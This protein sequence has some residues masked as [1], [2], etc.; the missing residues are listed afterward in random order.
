MKLAPNC[1]YLLIFW[2]A[3]YSSVAQENRKLDSLLEVYKKLPDDTAKV[4]VLQKIFAEQMSN[5]KISDAQNFARIQLKL[6]KKINYDEGTGKA[7]SNLAIGYNS[8]YV[9]DSARYYYAK[10]YKL[11]EKIGDKGQLLYTKNSWAKVEHLEGNYDKALAMYDETSKMAVEINDGVE[12]FWA[13]R[14]KASVYMDKGSYKLALQEFL[15]SLKVLDTLEGNYKKEKGNILV[16]MGR[17]ED[18]RENHEAS[19]K[20]LDEAMDVFIREENSIWQCITHTEMGLTYFHMGEYEKS[21]DKFNNALDISIRLERKNFE[22]ICYAN[23]GMVLA[24]NGNPDKALEYLYRSLKMTK[25]TNSNLSTTYNDIGNAFIVK[26]NFSKAIENYTYAIQL[27]E[28]V[29]GIGELKNSHQLRSMAFEQS[30]QYKEALQ[31]QKQYLVLNDSIFNT[32]KSQQ[33]EELRTIY[34]TEKKEQQI[35]LQEKE[36]TVLEQK[37]SISSLQRI[38]M[39]IGLLLSLIGF[40]AIR[41]KLKRNKLEKEKLDVELDF[42]K[43]ELTT[44]ALH[45]AKK[46]EVLEGLKQKAEELKTSDNGQN[47]YQQLIRTINFDL[48]NDNNWQNFSKYFQ[49]VHTNFN[50][51]VK[52]KFPKVTSNELRLMSLL[53]MNLSSKEIANILNISQEGIKKARYRLR[54]KLEITS[55]NSL[56]DLVLSL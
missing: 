11:W 45:L 36:I 30:G 38:V 48:Q 12:L 51:N 53:K 22:A 2:C 43:K 9:F 15:I 20:Y 25:N 7:L 46:N 47:G 40:Y 13:K 42:K 19:M 23:I 3:I 31:D 55:E 16:G 21:L 24:K 26:K 41:Q 6:S 54:K 28:S 18:L 27:S 5:G 8:T 10:S 52:K 14:D 50:S 37:A 49:Q 44:H 34:D 35:A 29:G 56:Q 1:V 32:T 39:G 4:D 33:I 17:I